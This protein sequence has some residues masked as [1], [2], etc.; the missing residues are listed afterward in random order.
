MRSMVMGWMGLGLMES[1]MVWVLVGLVKSACACC[2]LGLLGVL[3][4][5]VAMR[6]VVV[7]AVAK[8]RL[9]SWCVSGERV[10]SVVIEVLSWLVMVVAVVFAAVAALVVVLWLV[11]LATGAPVGE[12]DVAGVGCRWIPGVGVWEGGQKAGGLRRR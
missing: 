6:L 5:V 10:G 12:G 3:G 1:V 2:V 8:K 11:S 4:W 9:M 7:L